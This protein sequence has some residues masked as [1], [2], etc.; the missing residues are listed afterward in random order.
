VA[1]SGGMSGVGPGFV[2]GMSLLS[3][4]GGVGGR[5]SSEVSESGPEL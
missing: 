1:E 2:A 5:V 4:T 3:D